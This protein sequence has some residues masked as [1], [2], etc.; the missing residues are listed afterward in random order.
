[1]KTFVTLCLIALSLSAC[2]IETVEPRFDPRD[3]VVGRYEAEEYSETYHDFTYYSLHITKSGYSHEIRLDNF[4][5]ADISVYAVLDQ[6][7]ITIPF[8]VKD[9][10]EI[11]GVGTVYGNEIDL[12]YSV[13]DRYNGS[14]TDFCETKLWLEY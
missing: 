9:G 4:Y 6:D 8:Q 13:R 10:Y 11:E 7:R 12:H 14:R 3:R 1:M 5:A 2:T